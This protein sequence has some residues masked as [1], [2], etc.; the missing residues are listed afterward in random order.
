[1]RRANA[2]RPPEDSL[3]L[4]A[5]VLGAVVTGAVALAAVG[6][7][8]FGGIVLVVA[9][10]VAGYAFS[11]VYR[12]PT[13]W[14]WVVKVL[15]TMG[16]LLA[17]QQFFSSLRALQTVDEA[18]FP[19]ASLFLAVQVLHGFDLPARKDLNFSLGSSLA[20]MAIAATL[21]QD[22][23]YAFFLVTYFGF[24]MAA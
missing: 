20:L 22:M 1:M 5:A 2:P 21:A 12:Y 6:A 14:K 13:P 3:A 7:V 4:R 10:L 24:V 16:A 15:L 9:L 8:S 19:L 23:V 11:H 17:L 18:R